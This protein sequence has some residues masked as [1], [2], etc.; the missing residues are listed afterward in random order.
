VSRIRMEGGESVKNKSGVGT[1]G[2]AS[3]HLQHLR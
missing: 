3:V 1:D 2:G